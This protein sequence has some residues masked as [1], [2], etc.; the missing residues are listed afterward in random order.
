MMNRTAGLLFALLIAM[1]A[2]NADA[3]AGKPVKIYILAG[4]SNMNTMQRDVELLKKS[5]PDVKFPPENIWFVEGGYRGGV[6]RGGSKWG[7]ETPF[8]LDLT[9]EIKE[10]VLLFK[11]NKGG[12]T[13]TK[14]WRPPST[15]K[16]LGGKVGYLYNRM[17]R[18]FHN[19]IKNIEDIYPPV[20]DRGYE[21]AAFIW[22]QGESDTGG[23]DPEVWK[24]YEQK[25]KELIADV[26]RDTGVP[27]LPFLNIQINNI[28]LWDGKPDKPKGGATIR[29]AQKKVAQE[30][31]KGVWIS[32][33]NLSK[34]YHYDANAYLVIGKRMAEAMMPLARETVMTD[35]T[36]ITDAGKAFKTRVYPDT[37]PDV[38]S[39]RKGLIFHLPFER[40][41]KPTVNDC[42]GGVKGKI[43]GKAK[44]CEGLFG[45]GISMDR[46]AGKT[47]TNRIEFPDFKDPVKGGVI[48]SLSISFWVQTPSGHV[49]DAIT[50]Y[51]YGK[52][53]NSMKDGWRMVISAYGHTG[54][55]AIID[56]V[57]EWNPNPQKP[58]KG[59]PPK[60][61]TPYVHAR[62]AGSSTAFGD[63]VEWHHVVA[64]YDG[65]AKTMRTYVDA[66]LKASPNP[67]KYPWAKDIDG[68]GVKPSTAPLTI[69]SCSRSPGMKSAMDEISIWDRAL[70]DD[71]IKTLYNNGNGVQLK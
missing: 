6:P 26:R 19:M 11:S 4:Q 50:K 5:Y 23:D 9:K 18:R 7:V 25:L 52:E 62:K 43:V 27:N 37:K 47:N 68:K 44:Y 42:I 65:Q 21:I 51:V 46:V 34:G 59:K 48:E 39:L 2:L 10:P 30:D 49:G 15:V 22:F 3:I 63:G 1:N 61:G 31:P 60:K 64:V 54:M 66:G 12:T 20:K 36:K 28:P 56:G 58:K 32:T 8:V 33:S 24:D 71:E 41:G 29:A 70:T 45:K 67:K 55:N 69:H 53:H 13:L 57:T 40:E 17:I 38:S 16:R 14:D 35:P